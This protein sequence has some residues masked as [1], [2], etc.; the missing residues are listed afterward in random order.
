ML[1]SHFLAAIALGLAGAGHCLGMCGGIALAFRGQS[2]TPFFMSVG[3]HSGRLLSYG[4]LGALMGGAAGAIEL[5]PWTITLRFLAGF[6]L[7]GMGLHTLQLWMGIRYLESL[8]GMLWRRVSPL[9]T[10]LLPPKNIYHGA[11]LGMLWGLMPCGL[12]Y[13]AL[14]WSAAAA[15]NALTSGALMLAF[16]LGT[17][18]AMLGTTLISSS[19][20]RFLRSQWL[21]RLMG[22]LLVLAGLWSLW[23]TASHTSHLLGSYQTERHQYSTGAHA[24]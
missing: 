22:S 12:I 8:G 15:G 16:G 24:R 19:A 1:D 13:S 11:L 20:Q 7:L 4:L 21:R 10:A 9:T 5:A 3:Y 14:A 18:P 17:L 6:L 2:K 23:S